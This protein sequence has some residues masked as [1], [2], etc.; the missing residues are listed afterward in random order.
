L[1]QDVDIVPARSDANLERLVAALAPFH[2]YL[3]GAPP[4]LPF[5]WSARTLKQELNFALTTIIGDIDVLGEITGGGRYEDLI[6][7]TIRVPLF[8]AS[9][10]CLNLTTLIYTKRAAGCPRDLEAI[11][12]LE[13]LQEE[14]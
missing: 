9:Y 8:G 10:A 6:A 11:A 3:R 14:E 5:E 12:E 7:R 1:T 13:A 4:G 2:P